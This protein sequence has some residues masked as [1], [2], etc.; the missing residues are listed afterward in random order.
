MNNIF[1]KISW[2]SVFIL[3]IGALGAS[4]TGYANDK[5]L[6]KKRRSPE[7]PY[8]EAAYMREQLYVRYPYHRNKDCY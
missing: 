4:L 1:K 7:Y 3:V 6:D 2:S 8:I 5:E